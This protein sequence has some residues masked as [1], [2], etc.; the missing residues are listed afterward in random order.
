MDRE[1]FSAR[2]RVVEAQ[3]KENFEPSTMDDL[4]AAQNRTTHAVRSLAITFVA[5]PII[6]LVVFVVIALAIKSGNVAII[7]IAALIGLLT[8][9]GVLIVALDELRASRI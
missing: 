7:I 6:M 8:L 1:T 5:S 4:V 3:P 2:M 9:I